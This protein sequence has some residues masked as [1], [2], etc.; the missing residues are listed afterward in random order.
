[1]DPAEARRRDHRRQDAL[2][3]YLRL[4][5]PRPGEVR[6][7]GDPR[8][9]RRSGQPRRRDQSGDARGVL[10]VAGQS[11]HAPGRHRRRIRHRPPPRRADGGRQHLLHALPA[12]SAR[13]RRRLRAAFGDQVPRRPRRPAR[14]CHRRP[15]GN[16]DPGALL[17]PQGHDRRRA[18]G[19]G[20]LPG[21]ARPQDPGAAH[22]PPLRQRAGRGRI[23]CRAPQGFS[24]AFPR[25]AGLPP[26]RTG[27]APDG[28]SPAA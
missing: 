24:G 5:Q 4:P 10:R 1:M 16:I 27:P 26:V 23:P 17:R 15:C 2:R 25:P 19:A 11:Q 18:L 9:P 28:A 13:T 6:R 14:R 12:A 8:R 22:G 7:Q 20:C 3:L 21:V